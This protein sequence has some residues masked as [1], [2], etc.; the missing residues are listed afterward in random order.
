M[1]KNAVIKKVAIRIGKW[2]NVIRNGI[3]G[4]YEISINAT[5][6]LDVKLCMTARLQGVIAKKNI[7]RVLEMVL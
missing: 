3:L 2:D 1:V 5:V 4:S 6:P 7:I